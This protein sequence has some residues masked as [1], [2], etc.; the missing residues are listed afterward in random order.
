MNKQFDGKTIRD[1]SLKQ[2]ADKNAAASRPPHLA[3]ILAGDNPVCAKYVELKKKSAIRAGITFSDYQFDNTHSQQE[4]IECIQHL[5]DDEEIDGI[6]IQI[7]VDLKFDRD[8]LIKSISPKKDVDGLRYCLGLDSDFKPP[9]VE[10]ILEALRLASLAQGKTSKDSKVVLVGSGFLVGKP[11]EKALRE[12]GVSPVVIS[13]GAEKS[14]DTR[15]ISRQARDDM[16]NS[17]IIITATGQSDLIKPD[18][19]KEGVVL[20]DAGTTE[21]NGC[22]VG[23][24]DPKCYEK[25]SYYT[26]VPGGIGPVTIAKLFENLTK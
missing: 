26:P 4:I 7:P 21:A 24:I 17:D 8:E 5:N 13:T 22:L 2:I 20:I 11:L 23:D 3:V 10:A 19:I 1:R 16:K 18:M 25:S 12:I 14:S 6:M 15:K 9:V